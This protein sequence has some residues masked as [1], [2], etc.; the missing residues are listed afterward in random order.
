MLGHHYY[1]RNNRSDGAQRLDCH[2]NDE[3]TA[4]GNT[5]LYF[6]SNT[7]TTATLVVPSTAGSTD[8]VDF[9]RMEF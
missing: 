1:E 8:V 3:A 6:S 4:A 9:S 2:V 5:N 7:T